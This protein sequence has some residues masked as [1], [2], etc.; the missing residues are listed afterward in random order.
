MAMESGLPISGEE[1]LM[2][3]T[4]PKKRDAKSLRR[5]Q[6]PSLIL[7]L[8]LTQLLA[9]WG[10]VV[11]ATAPRSTRLTNTITGTLA[12]RVVDRA[13][14]P[15]PRARVRAVNLET[16]NQRATLTNQEGRYQIAFL[17]MGRY[18][19]EA[20]KDGFEVVQPT[21]EP[22]KIQLNKT[23]ETV[24]DIVLQ[25]VVAPP[26]GGGAPPSPPPTPPV[27]PPVGPPAPTPA[28]PA[29][30]AP[31]RVTNLLDPTRRANAD[32]RML[33]LLPLAGVRTFDDLALLAAGVVPPPEVK[34]V[35]G[36]GIGAGIG[37]AGQFSV[38]GQRA[39]S[40]NFTVD[41]SDNNDEDVGV[42]RQ[43]FVALVPQSIESTREIQI[44]THLWDAENGRNV[45]SQVNAVSRAGTNQVH[46]TL[47]QFFN[48]DALNARNFFDYSAAQTPSFPLTATVIDR[49]QRGVPVNP[50]TI[51]VVIRPNSVAAPIPL[52]QPNPAE[53][54]DP[55][56]RL[57]GGAAVGL[58]IRKGQTFF[59]GS[60]ERQQIQARQ[61]THFAVPTVAQ[62]G[63]LNFGGSGF[64]VG[65]DD[66]FP[67][68]FTP[69][70]V[71]G[72]S[73]FSLFPFPNHPV[74]PY[75][76]NTFTQVLPADGT[77][78]LFSLK[79]DHAFRL[80]GGE[81]THN[82]TGRY[83]DTRD[84]RQV[85][86]VGGAIFSGVKPEVRTHNLS[87][88]LT[89]QL[90]PALA[91]QL[92]ASYGRTRLRFTE[93]RDPALT[94]SRLAPGEPFLLN[95]RRLSNLSSPDFPLPFVDYRPSSGT[96][97]VESGLGPVGQ[98]TISPFSPV[99]LDVYLFPQA[100]VNN[101]IQVADTLTAFRGSQTWKVGADLRR[102]Q[103]NSFLNR[104]FRPQLFFAGSPDLTCLI[105]QAPIRE[106]TQFG[107]TP[108][109]R[110]GT[111]ESPGYFSGTDLAAL[112]IPTGIFQSLALG[113]PDS[114]I[115]LRFWQYNAFLNNNWRARQG[116]TLD[117]GIRYEYNTVPREVNRR[118]ERTFGGLPLPTADPSYQVVAPFTSGQLTFDTA[119][120]L[121]S[122]DLTRRALSLFLDGR[123]EIFQPDRNNVGGHVGFAWDPAARSRTQAGKTVLRGGAGVYYDVTLGS[124]VS[125]SRNVFPTFIPFNVDVNT[126]SYAQDLFFQP[127]LSGNIAVF[128]PR[129]V[130]LELRRA[131]ALT[132][133]PL[134]RDGSLN[135]L[136]IPEG[137]IPAVL[138]LLFNP[139]AVGLRPSGGGLAF[140]LPEKSLRAPT[141]FQFNLQ[142]ERELG[143]EILLNVAYVGSRGVG[144]TRFRTP[145]GG[146][147]AITLPVDPIGLTQ[148][149]I[150]AVALPPLGGAADQS[151]RP[152]PHLGAYTV[153]DSSAASSYHALQTTLSR[154][155]LR[156]I[157]WTAAYTWSHAID[158]VSDVFDLAGSF[159]LPQDDRAMRLE[160]G[161][162]AFD[163]RHRFVGSLLGDLPLLGRYQKARGLTGALLGG[164]QW[165]AISTWQT[166][167]PYTVNTTYDVN[168]DGN[169]TDRIDSTRTIRA[170][171]QGPRLLSVEGSLLDLLA[172]LGENGRVGRNTWRARGVFKTDLSFSK[173]ITIRNDQSLTFR[174]E[175]FNVWNRSHFAIPVRILESP[176]FGA[177]VN[178][179][180]N[181][182][183]VQFAL[184]YLF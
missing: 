180:V 8:I 86:A 20:G 142:L 43:G 151:T 115:G 16:G 74:G 51:P 126:F 132:S 83:N 72:D 71:A 150:L 26:G 134:I 3:L 22:I 143:R 109:P 120:L 2:F 84:Q 7:T 128:N 68:T 60:F 49:F 9:P 107:P 39:R 127:G 50:R 19:L 168:L 124:V 29:D 73:V 167:Q 106:I 28:L 149:P 65:S 38:N 101:T 116:L 69:T 89:S 98:V 104:N 111:C 162:A 81:K 27:T 131:G 112:G 17:S 139:G 163:I 117:L 135:A 67:V 156:G 130:P 95:A 166:G 172:P 105:D 141:T 31:G 75:G 96:F 80:F 33:E 62:R 12:G 136:N 146:P 118:I 30:D 79:I 179:L 46:G 55:F 138:G 44:V 77:A 165:G 133:R 54:E 66:G 99:G 154:R 10:G 176:A 45:G 64:S 169:L 14:N 78:T 160:R 175:A 36:P 129:F 24:P 11:A 159:A 58:P 15:V 164:W 59:F 41:G 173:Q 102:T 76:P 122:Y 6:T 178:T 155:F 13:G 63:F 108:S 35:S 34:G 158:E 40:N 61:E 94:P 152:N 171:S 53:G 110:L 5:W 56:Q 57:Q 4:P 177:A 32:E 100:R 157:Q 18:V 87:L 137:A 123:G 140:T 25:P 37:T 114:T 182:R 153:F 52:V 161:S 1:T 103:L 93:R 183:Q 82:L 144:L 121:N 47:Y 97:D 113:T 148:N 174:V 42:R 92:R 145:N 70:F 184:K 119:K 21:R 147:N 85:P 90:S 88:F 91:N 48:H 23:F 125:Q 170:L 181:P